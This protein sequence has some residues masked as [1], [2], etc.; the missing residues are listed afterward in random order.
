MR[1]SVG[2]T[3]VEQYSA[4]SG[5]SIVWP[6]M[7]RAPPKSA[8]APSLPERIPR[9]SP[10]PTRPSILAG[11]SWREILE[12]D[13]ES[14]AVHGPRPSAR[15][16]GGGG[17]GGGGGGQGR[18]AGVAGL[19]ARVVSGMKMNCGEEWKIEREEAAEGEGSVTDGRDDKVAACSR[20]PA[21]SEPSLK[22]EVARRY[23][24]GGT[25]APRTVRGLVPTLLTRWTG[26]PPR[27]PGR[28]ARERS[29]MPLGH[30][31]PQL[32]SSGTGPR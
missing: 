2:M 11:K 29:C 9:S 1:T 23:E 12:G 18:H 16:E 14:M 17:G 13:D 24:G 32:V 6:A 10:S 21:P 8:C 19:A 15:G 28:P 5:R 30:G 25:H 31:Q 26:C 7:P 4:P 3:Q 20:R 27:S 22:G